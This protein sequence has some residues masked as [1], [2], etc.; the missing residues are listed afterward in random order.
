[1]FKYIPII[2]E[3]IPLFS[4]GNNNSAVVLLV[5]PIISFFISV[6]DLFMACKYEAIGG[7]I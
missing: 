2:K 4:I 7:D 3:Y 6:L 1:M 5:I